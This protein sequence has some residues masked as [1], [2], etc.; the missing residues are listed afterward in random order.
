MYYLEARQKFQYDSAVNF[1]ETRRS[2]ELVFYDCSFV[3]T[4]SAVLKVI[5]KNVI[6]SAK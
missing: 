2:V 3:D 6:T 1:Q 4:N 5:A